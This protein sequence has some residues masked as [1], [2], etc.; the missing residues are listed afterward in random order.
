M[1]DVVW[2]EEFADLL[3]SV[4]PRL[5]GR[6]AIPTDEH[7]E[8]LGA[9]SLVLIQLLFGLEETYGIVFP[10]ELLTQQTFATA[11]TLWEATASLIDRRG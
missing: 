7:L 2:D 8:R 9:D 4:L 3:R 1:T 6:D 10:Q 5:R 11:A